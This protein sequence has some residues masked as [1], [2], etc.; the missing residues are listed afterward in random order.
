M[1]CYCVRIGIVLSSLMFVSAHAEA[2]FTETF[3]LTASDGA[4]NDEFGSYISSPS[5]AVSGT[6]AVVGAHLHDHVG[7][8]NQSGGAYIF[9]TT[10]GNELFELIP[11]GFA[12][13]DAFGYS[14]AV[15]GNIAVVGALGDDEEA[16]SAGVA[17]VFD[18][19]T[20]NQLVK[21]TAS[22]AVAGD[23]LGGAVAVSG[24]TALVGTKDHNSDAGAVY[25]F[26]TTTG[27]E[28][29]KLTAS[30]A[31]GGDH[32]GGSVAVSGNIAVIGARDNDD[33]GNSSG[34]AY[35]FD[36]TTGNELFKLT[37]TSADAYDFFGCSVAVSGNIAVIGAFFDD[38]AASDAGAAYVFDTTTGN[39]LFK[40]TPSDGAT[41]DYFGSSVA[42]SGNIA[43]IGALYDDDTGTNSGSVYI[44][45]TT[46]GNE[47]FKLTASDAASRDEFG[48]SVAASGDLVVIGAPGVNDDTGATYVLEAVL[49]GDLNGDGYVGIDDL[50]IVLG[51]WSQSVPPADE[52][53]D[54]SGDGF[55]GSADLNIVLRNWGAGTPPNAEVIAIPEPTSA[56]LMTGI[57]MLVSRR[58]TALR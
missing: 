30:D 1:R 24:T 37:A 5:V 50:N 39:E 58:R 3:K 26:D 41:D 20:G 27:N 14:V 23:K 28:L 16:E 25:V 42:V 34:A 11:S 18:T 45:D 46:N 10:T 36:T 6:T 51:A 4:A 31:A 35:V 40:L 53:A 17:Y 19:T 2:Q 56:A 55:V 38:G 29:F 43:V 54:P 15:S 33:A 32:F 22:D 9:D 13:L 48:S 52:A 8:G 49:V 21:L 44:F 57:A 12:S 7:V 47:L